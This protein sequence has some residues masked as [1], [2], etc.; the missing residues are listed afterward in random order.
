MYLQKRNNFKNSAAV[1][2]YILEGML[3]IKVIKIVFIE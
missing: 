3:L 2:V 1:L